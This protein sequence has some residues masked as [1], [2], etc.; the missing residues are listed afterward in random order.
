MV[1]GL[2]AFGVSDAGALALS[3]GFGLTIVVAGV[4]GVIL[5]IAGAGRFSTG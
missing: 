3:I 1:F 2:T 4:I 5:W